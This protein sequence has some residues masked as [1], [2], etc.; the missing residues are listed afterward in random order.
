M[1]E[2]D[3]RYEE[4]YDQLLT[5]AESL[6]EINKKRIRRGLIGL[7]VL[8]VVLCL[9]LWLT[10]SDKIVFLII[11]V[12]CMFALCAYLIGV[13]YLD[14]LIKKNVKDMLD[15][16]EINGEDVY[17]D[18]LA[19]RDILWKRLGMRMRKE[20]KDETHLSDNNL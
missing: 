17:D 12:V 7:G 20:G 3:V 5:K 10:E 2:R 19:D 13:E 14:D 1:N 6:H 15:K 8:P 16:E 18:L 9:I 11:W 4:L